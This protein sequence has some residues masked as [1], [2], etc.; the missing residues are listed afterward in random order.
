MHIFRQKN[1]GLLL[2]SLKQVVDTQISYSKKKDTQISLLQPTDVTSLHR[3]PSRR[4]TTEYQ[5][6]ITHSI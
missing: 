5:L 3:T 6:N 1:T 2:S 4:E